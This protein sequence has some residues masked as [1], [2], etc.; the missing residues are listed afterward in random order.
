MKDFRKMLLMVV[1]ACAALP[2][3]ADEDFAL[4]YRGRITA[5]QEMPSE[6]E[7]TYSLY[8]REEDD[9][10]SHV[11]RQTKTERPAANGAFQSVLSGD[12][13]QAAF[14]DRKA[15]FLG[16]RLGGT[17]AP[18]QYPRQEILA[19][20]LAEYA[21]SADGLPDSPVFVNATVGTLAAETL[22]A[23]SLTVTNLLT[24]SGGNS[25]RLGN[26][27]PGDGAKLSVRKPANGSVRLFAGEPRTTEIPRSDGQTSGDVTPEYL[28]PGSVIFPVITG[29]GGLVMAMTTATSWW[30]QDYAAPCITWAIGPGE[31]PSAPVQIL[32]PAKFWFYEFGN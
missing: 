28:W 31:T 18:E 13:L 22:T 25:L 1:A 24:V 10:A 15:R 2:A 3:A 14:E 19:V 27:A 5:Q 32:L 7:V 21:D 9:D 4:T 16:I 12:G 20:P 23:S 11:W 8:V 26:M 17:N 30:N 29:K 6:L